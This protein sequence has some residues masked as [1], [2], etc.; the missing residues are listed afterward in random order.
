M[1]YTKP[2]PH[3]CELI[4]KMLCSARDLLYPE[5]YWTRGAQARDGGGKE[6]E[7]NDARAIRFCLVGAIRYVAKKPP[8]VEEA[9]P[10]LYYSLPLSCRR[11]ELGRHPSFTMENALSEWNDGTAEHHDVLALIDRAKDLVR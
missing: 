2:A 3:N 4:M 10:T 9:L 6:V 8:H 11:D 5:H 1:N 7:P